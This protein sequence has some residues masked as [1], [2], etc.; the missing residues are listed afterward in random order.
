MNPHDERINQALPQI[1]RILGEWGYADPIAP[2]RCL[3]QRDI[4]CWLDNFKA[5]ELNDALLLLD[6][7]QYKDEKVIRDAISRLSREL[8]V[9]YR[10]PWPAVSTRMQDNSR[11]R[12]VD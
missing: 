2:S 3:K 6:K 12:A 11:N 8:T 5:S 4:L 9:I 1:M 10:S 7:I